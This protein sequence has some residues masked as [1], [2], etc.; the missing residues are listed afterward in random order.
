MI[1][2][3]FVRWVGLPKSKPDRP[4]TSTGSG[5]QEICLMYECLATARIFGKQGKNVYISV[6]GPANKSPLYF[7]TLVMS[8]A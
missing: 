2:L 8:E 1:C 3:P 4:L 7:F 5:G 6:V